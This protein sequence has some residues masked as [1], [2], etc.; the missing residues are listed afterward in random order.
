[1]E[2]NN[3]ELSFLWNVMTDG[4]FPAD[5]LKEVDNDCEIIIE[6]TER[7]TEKK[8]TIKAVIDSSDNPLEV[9]FQ[10]GRL[11]QSLKKY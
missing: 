7:V 11:V 1:M 9:A 6:T 3:F 8:V 10:I 2:K 5:K 4:K